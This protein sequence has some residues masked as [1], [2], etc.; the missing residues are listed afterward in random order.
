MPQIIQQ[1]IT[2]QIVEAIK[3]VC[4][5]DINFIDTN[6]IIFASTNKKRI[7]DYH[8]IGKS[9]AQTGKSI[10]VTTDDSFAGTQKGVNIPFIYK[11]EITAVIGITGIPE[12]VRKYAYLAQKITMLLLREHELELHEH[13]QKTQINHM[14]RSIIYN[15]HINQDYLSDFLKKYHINQYTLYQ[16][17]IVKLNSHYNPSNFS[18]IE[19]HIYYSFEQTGSVLYTF[20]YP[21]EYI[22]L[23]K[24]NNQKKCLAILKKL[25][26]KNVPFL[27]IGIGN[28]TPLSKQHQSYHC[29]KIALQSLFGTET[30]AIFDQLDLEIL[31]GS[32]TEETKEYFLKRTIFSLSKKEQEL[33]KTYFANN[34]SL[35]ET[36]IQHYLHK[37]TLQYQLD[38]IARKTGFNP[39]KFKE[40]VILYI[41]L[42]IN[43]PI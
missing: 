9:V 21:N 34:M 33:L 40:A 37:N 18:A 22:L 39:R 1:A 3:D 20:N 23:I 6:G 30:I 42:K 14:I 15:D 5:H 36:C 26:E 16:T 41:A 13:T 7:G 2:Q 8:E 29:A 27:Q 35:K 24:A 10:E 12:E 11:G 25:A 32:L 43:D 28:A 4:E 19:S 31:L 17:I 38:K